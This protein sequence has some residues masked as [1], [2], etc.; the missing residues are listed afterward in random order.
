MK[1]TSLKLSTSL[2]LFGSVLATPAHAAKVLCSTELALPA[3][4][5]SLLG[6]AV[7]PKVITLENKCVGT[8][9]RLRISRNWLSPNVALAGSTGPQ[10]PT[11][12]AGPGL[13]T[14]V[15]ANNRVLGQLAHPLAPGALTSLDLFNDGA[16]VAFAI[17]V[18]DSGQPRLA[19][20]TQKVYYSSVDCSGTGYIRAYPN[21]VASAPAQAF[22]DH[23]GAAMRSDPASSALVT[24]DMLSYRDLAGDAS[25][26]AVTTQGQ[27]SPLAL[28]S[29]FATIP[30]PV[31]L[32]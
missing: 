24:S 5:M 25:C 15:D 22:R 32:Q 9:K 3:S 21:F 7:L 16:N 8:Q 27:F 19:T 28:E 14:V 30:G 10:G 20:G 2:M 13:P 23:A 1:C 31:R 26:Q 4:L 17:A 29:E 12:P 6:M 11:G 18:D